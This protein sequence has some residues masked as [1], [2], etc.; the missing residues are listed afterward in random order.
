MLEYDTDQTVKG[1]STVAGHFLCE[2]RQHVCCVKHTSTK[3]NVPSCLKRGSKILFKTQTN[4]IF[5]LSLLADNDM[6]Y[7]L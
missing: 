6:S 1:Q 3:I 2:I 7:I 5:L 4:C